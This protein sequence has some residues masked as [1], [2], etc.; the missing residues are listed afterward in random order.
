MRV[1]VENKKHLSNAVSLM[2]VTSSLSRIA[3]P[4]IAA[5]IIV[6]F[7]IKYCWIFIALFCLSIL[8]S[9]FFIK[10]TAYNRQKHLY[11]NLLASIKSALD[12]AKRHDIL[13]T[14]FL[15]FFIVT[16]FVPNY[17]VSIS[18]LVK[19]SFGA[20]DEDFVYVMSFLGLGALIGASLNTL[21]KHRISMCAIFLSGM[22][23]IVCIGATAFTNNI[24]TLGLWFAGTG[25]FFVIF[26]NLVITCIQTHGPMKLRGRIMSIYTLIY[27]GAA[28]IGSY[29]AG[30]L[31]DEF[32][33]RSALLVS[34]GASF[35]ILSL[36]LFYK[37][38]A[39]ISRNYI[40]N[41][42]N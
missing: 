30:Q 10:I 6:S 24:F 34:S 18:A 27:F 2:A 40:I 17:S 8:L 36:L 42:K 33:A 12:Y 3:G 19:M 22:S 35:V 38:F 11:K 41:S 32:G 25:F 21:R 28:P 5:L 20:S 16:V 31:A 14:S 13:L 9:L 4:S 7:G 29:I 39:G 26:T 1:L 23:S 37:I 15:A